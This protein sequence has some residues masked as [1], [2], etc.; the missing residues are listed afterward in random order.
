M[1][2]A[3]LEAERAKRKDELDLPR[4][5]TPR[6]TDAYVEHTRVLDMR[7]ERARSAAALVAELTAQIAPL[8]AW[9]DF[10]AAQRPK[11]CADL[12]ALVPD[13]RDRATMDLQQALKL[14]ISNIDRGATYWANGAAGVGAPL[15]AAIQAAGYLPRT[16]VPGVA[17]LGSLPATEQQLK[18]LR[19]QIDTA[20]AQL[21]E[22]L[23]DDATRAKLDA[24]GAARRAVLESLNLCGTNADGDPRKPF[25]A[26]RSDGTVL[27]ESEL[28]REQRT[29]LD[30]VNA[31]EYQRREEIHARQSGEMV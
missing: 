3:Q 4:T 9:R 20:Q 10:L 29:A 28:T 31:A 21:D 1:T 17:W 24:E 18:E 16:G 5:M 30:Q 25:V 27:P 12:I 6:E 23:L 2:L 26:R 8:E 7:I 15:A 13:Y 14:S 19:R 11:L 22:A